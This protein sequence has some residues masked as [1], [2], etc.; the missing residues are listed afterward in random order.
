MKKIVAIRCS[1]CGTLHVTDENLA[2]VRRGSLL[3][4]R[5]AKIKA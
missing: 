3:L 2:E 5:I 4:L 1:G